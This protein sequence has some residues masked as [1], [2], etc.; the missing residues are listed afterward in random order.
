MCA[1]VYHRELVN[2]RGTYDSDGGF[3]NAKGLCKACSEGVVGEKKV[4][5]IIND[6]EFFL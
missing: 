2:I 4:R 5:L 6:P 1:L 3:A